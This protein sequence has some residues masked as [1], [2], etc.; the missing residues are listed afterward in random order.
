MCG[1]CFHENEITI[2][3]ADHQTNVD[4]IDY[5]KFLIKSTALSS[6]DQRVTQHMK[7]ELNTVPPFHLMRVAMVASSQHMF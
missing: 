3:L 5:V 1:V 4:L 6:F 7:T 2:T